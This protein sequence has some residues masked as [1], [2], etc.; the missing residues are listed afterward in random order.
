MLLRT[1]DY[2]ELESIEVKMNNI[3]QPRFIHDSVTYALPMYPFGEAAIPIVRL[4]LRRIFSYRQIHVIKSMGQD[5]GKCRWH[6]D[7]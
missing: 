4:Q 2:A 3:F 7:C 5:P 1:R 6:V